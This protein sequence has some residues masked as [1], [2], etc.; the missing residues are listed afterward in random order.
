[1]SNCKIST[2]SGFRKYRE[3]GW[4]SPLNAPTGSLP[5]WSW[6]QATGLRPGGIEPQTLNVSELSR[7]YSTP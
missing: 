4:N 1:M 3:F 2:W 6:I 5:R 7:C